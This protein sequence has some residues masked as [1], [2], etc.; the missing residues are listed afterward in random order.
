MMWAM[1]K[2][3][4]LAD[5]RTLTYD[6]YGD[7]DG[8]PVIFNH[9]LTDSSL[10]RNPDNSLTA[11]LGVRVE[12]ARLALVVLAVSLV[13]VTSAVAGP[14][15]FVALA[16]PHIARRVTSGSG[17]QVVA[18]GLVGAVLVVVCDVVAQQVLAPVILPVGLVTIV[19]GGGYLTWLLGRQARRGLA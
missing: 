7:P 17:V 8:T 2:S 3:L 6:E 15:T 18:S 19:L 1:G 9:G 13:A 10:I 5:G 11:S 4:E 14:I 12:R 16:A